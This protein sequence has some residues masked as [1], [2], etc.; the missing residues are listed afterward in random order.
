MTTAVLEISSK[1]GPAFPPIL[2]GKVILNGENPFIRL[3][4]APGDPLSTDASLWTITY[5][6]K[7]AGHALFIRSELTDDQWRIYTDNLEMVRWLQSTVQGMLAPETADS[8]I[9]VF[10]ATFSREG[11]TQNSWTQK[12][13]A[14]T[15]EIVLTWSNFLEP[16]LMAHKQPTDLPERPY[17]TSLFMIPAQD[18]VLTLNGREAAGETWPVKYDGQPFSTSALA[19]SESW[20]EADL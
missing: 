8:D 9:P 7:G 4:H 12:V 10:E 17:G 5:S 20:R 18:A 11:N 3:S 16:L 13:H 6:P 19:F 15:D 2:P 1:A 14:A